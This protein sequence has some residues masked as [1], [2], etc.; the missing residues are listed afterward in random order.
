MQTV[1]SFLFLA[2]LAVAVLLCLRKPFAGLLIVAAVSPFYS[3]LRESSV[4]SPVFFVWPYVLVGVLIGVIAA[5]EIVRLLAARGVAR[6]GRGAALAIAGVALVIAGIVEADAGFL[7]ALLT[8]RGLKSIGTALSS[9]SFLA[10]AFGLCAVLGIFIAWFPWVM[11]RIEGRLS[12]VDLAISTFLLVGLISVVVTYARNGV[13]FTG[14]NGFRYYFALAL[15][16][17]PAR[18]FMRTR[19]QR[20]AF[21]TVL[22]VATIAGAV[23]LLLESFLLNQLRIPFD[24]L[25]WAGPLVREFGYQPEPRAF[26]N[27]PLMPVGFM[28][29]THVSG[30]FLLLG[31][32]IAAPVLLARDSRLRFQRLHLA[33]AAAAVI[34][35]IWTSRTVLLLLVAAFLAAAALVPSTW[36]RRIAGAVLLCALSGVT[37]QWLIPGARYDLWREVTFLST[38]ALPNLLGAIV[39]DIREILGTK[40]ASEPTGLPEGWK[41]HAKGTT[42]RTEIAD[43]RYAVNIVAE[44]SVDLRTRVPE[45]LA[46]D[47]EPL[48]VEASLDLAPGSSVVLQF[49]DAAGVIANTASLAAGGRQLLVLEGASRG[50]PLSFDLD[51]SAGGR[52]TVEHVIFSGLGGAT[53]SLGYD[54]PR[55]S[56]GGWRVM[57]VRGRSERAAI[58]GGAVKL[59]AGAGEL[60]FRY[61]VPPA[62]TARAGRM[63]VTADVE[64]PPG[65]PVT[66]Q[67]VVGDRVTQVDKPGTG[68]P[69]VLEVSAAVGRQ[70]V[71]IDIDVPPHGTAVVHDVRA[72]TMVASASLLHQPL[73]IVRHDRGAPPA[74]EPRPRADM[75]PVGRPSTPSEVPAVAVPGA[76]APPVAAVPVAAPAAR[77]NTTIKALL[78]GH[79]AEFGTWNQVFFASKSSGEFAAATYSDTKY[80]EFFQQFGALGLAA[81]LFVGLAPLWPAWRLWRTNAAPYDRAQ[82]VGIVIMIGIGFVSLLHLPSMFKIG[83]GTAVFIAMAI[84]PTLEAERAAR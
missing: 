42:S 46:A 77:A 51:V 35:S 76:H 14:L 83:F 78:L 69:M 62:M 45:G 60:D 82:I 70:A 2:A 84:I 56:P 32:A 74:G 11:R 9:R 8:D 36:R 71:S 55:W 40:P 26:F 24:R 18:Y 4:G 16:Y 30:L 54:P 37:A 47:G 59:S 27:A 67:L 79:G 33:V 73:S 53:A 48:Q 81:L 1:Y 65:Q 38:S 57:D 75:P 25:P 28:Y 72:Q 50:A 80:L 44:E 7:R 64:A 61:A 52:V 66:L 31:F 29:M 68:G 13:I 10:A 3:L 15:T 21:F 6:P 5:R 19:D 12:I 34:G 58:S 23:Q 17:L 41:L 63:T 39:I 20:R 49:F 43:G 22:A